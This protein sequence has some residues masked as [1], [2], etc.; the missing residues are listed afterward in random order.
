MEQVV[1]DHETPGG[2]NEQLRT[3]FFEETGTASLQKALDEL[4]ARVT[5]S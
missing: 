3:T 5:G 4:H 1:S 2:L